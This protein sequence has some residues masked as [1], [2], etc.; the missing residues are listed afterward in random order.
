MKNIFLTGEVG[1]GKSTV[2]QEILSLL[3]SIVCGGFRTVSAAPV[4]EGVLLDVFIEKAWEKTPH[5]KEHLVGSRLGDGHFIPYP[6]VFNKVGASIL[7][8][9]PL[10]AR[11]VLMDELG[12]MESSAKEFQHVVL[13]SLDGPLPVLGVIKPK[14]TDFLDA[15]RNHDRSEIFEV[16]ENNRSTLP[17]HLAAMLFADLSAN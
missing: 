13:N 10:G 8:H 7:Y 6:D 9:P 16:T 2:I 11:L 12:V 15:I 14:H 1:I 3:P 4:S 17:S 5:D